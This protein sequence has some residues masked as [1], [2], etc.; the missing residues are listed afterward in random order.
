[1]SFIRFAKFVLVFCFLFFSITTKAKIDSF[2]IDENI[3]I[4]FPQLSEIVVGMD[5]NSPMLRINEENL[6]EG[7]A[8][9]MIADSAQSL[10]ADLNINT[11]SIYENRPGVSYYQ[12]YK[13]IGSIYI[14]KPFFQWGAIKAKSRIAE[15]S[16]NLVFNDSDNAKSDLII[17]VKSEFLNIVLL[18]FELNLAKKT[19]HLRNKNEENLRKRN[20]LGL[21]TELIVNE[22]GIKKLEQSIQVSELERIIQ[23]RKSNF[24][25]DTGY[26]KQL[27]LNMSVDFKN[28][29]L[30]H[31]I[32]LKIPL[33]VG[34]PSSNE[35]VQ[36]K[37]QI[38]IQ[39]QKIIVANSAKKPKLNLVGAFFQDQIDL[40][41]D[42]D[43]VRRNNFLIGFE[44]NWNLWDSHLSRGRKT[45]AFA[46]KRKLDI[47]LESKTRKLR[48]EVMDLQKQLVN[49]STQINLSRELVNSAKNRFEKSQI[50]LNT[51]RIT[52][53]NH[54]E[55]EISLSNANLNLVRTVFYYMQIKLQYESILN[56]SKS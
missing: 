6:K 9:R 14:R 7:S 12:N 51:K 5:I 40:V 32:G 19:L 41:D 47:E 54:F 56:Y 29:Y 52:S 21:V 11:Y 35:I 48:L 1:M 53:I 22:A 31:K 27:D 16:E 25:Y 44:A 42:Q 20:E 28:F 46:K 13:T 39:N 4:Y 55:S 34:S 36:L 23:T 3:E 10:T 26:N 24:V 2:N 43:S 30:A 17:H 49:L 33:L 45:L 15:L 38:E 8:N 18:S 37:S 50:E